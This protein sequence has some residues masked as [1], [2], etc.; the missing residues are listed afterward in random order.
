MGFRP[1][2]NQL[3]ERVIIL[4][5]VIIGSFPEPQHLLWPVSR[6]LFKGDES[7]ET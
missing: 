5:E 4:S 2:S 1:E 7:S 3:C 6:E